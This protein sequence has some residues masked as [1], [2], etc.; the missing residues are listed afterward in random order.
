MTPSGIGRLVSLS[1]RRPWVDRSFLAYC[2]PFRSN[3]KVV[4]KNYKTLGLHFVCH[5]TTISS[6]RDSHRRPE[7]YVKVFSQILESSISVDY[8]QRHIFMDLLILADREGVIDMTH[9]AIARRLNVPESLVSDNIAK[10]EQPDPKSRSEEHDGRRLVRLADH[11]D[12]GWRV[13]NYGFYRDLV[14]AETLRIANRE[15]KREQ[16]AKE[17]AA[18]LRL[19]KAVHNG[20]AMSQIV[21]DSHN[22]SQKVTLSDADADALQ[23]KGCSPSGEKRLLSATPAFWESLKSDPAFEG[24]DF[25]EERR[26][27]AIWRKIAKNK[28]R[29]ITER[30]VI[31]WLSKADRNVDLPNLNRS[32]L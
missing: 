18:R 10:L 30:F 25:E 21:R 6:V 11:R 2:H 17:K 9:E 15:R 23:P 28:H 19:S 20:H 3:C 13:V 16:R 26:K 4:Q 5:G 27:M 22:G 31:N 14:D 1:A 12:W 7:M 24:I 8:E 29:Q 32:C